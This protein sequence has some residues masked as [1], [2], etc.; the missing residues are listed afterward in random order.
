[1]GRDG[2]GLNKGHGLNIGCI[3]KV[4]ILILIMNFKWRT[5]LVVGDTPHHNSCNVTQGHH[6]ET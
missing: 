3:D 2:Q 4:K 6:S 1:M 5:S